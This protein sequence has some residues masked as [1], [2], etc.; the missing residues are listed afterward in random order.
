MTPPDG[1]ALLSEHVRREIRAALTKLID[2]VQATGNR[3]VAISVIADWRD[4]HYPATP[5]GT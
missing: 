1:A 2:A 5:E 4:Q 3:D